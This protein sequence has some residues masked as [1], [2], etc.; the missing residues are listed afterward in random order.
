MF[1]DDFPSPRLD[2]IMNELCHGVVLDIGPGSGFQLKRFKGA[3]QLHKIEVIYGVEP[4][5]EMHDQLRAEATN[6][7]GEDAPKVYKVLSSGAQPNELVPALAKDS[8]LGKQYQGVFDTIVSL[9]A[10]CGIPQP[11]E[12]ADLFYQLLKPGGRIIFFEHVVNS[13]DSKRG[14][15]IVARFMQHVYMLMGWKIW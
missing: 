8:I 5:E 13:G 6:I 15:S 4:G 10:L 2:N 1:A 14:G 7:F 12:T 11:Q 3:H 9:R